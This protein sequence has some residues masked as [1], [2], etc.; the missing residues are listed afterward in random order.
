MKKFILCFLLVA[1]A[2]LA[3][4]KT[5]KPAKASQ[6][7][8]DKLDKA[9]ISLVDALV[10][11]DKPA[12]KAISYPAV[13]CIDCVGK[14]EFNKEGY[15]VTADIFYLNIANNFI[16]SPVYKA[17]AKRGYTFSTITIEDFKP[18][19]LPRDY[20]KDLQL[21]EVWVPTYIKGELS[22]THPGT[23]HAFQFIKV[24]GEF[25]FYGLTSIP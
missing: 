10:K 7:E 17:I 24:N 5:S 3:Q 1:T 4:T 21:Y 11:N 14:P 23:S 9:F 16:N 25:K 18:K 13:D 19:I 12:F 2:G 8:W 15:F 6:S 20:P 22:K